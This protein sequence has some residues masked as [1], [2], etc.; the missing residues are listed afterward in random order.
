MFC[1][2]TDYSPL[3]FHKSLQRLISGRGKSIN[4]K[5]SRRICQNPLRP[6]PSRN[7]IHKI[8]KIK[9]KIK[10]Q[11]NWKHPFLLMVSILSDTV[12]LKLL[13]SLG[14][15]GSSSSSGPKKRTGDI[16]SGLSGMESIFQKWRTSIEYFECPFVCD[17]DVM[18]NN[19]FLDFNLPFNAHTPTTPNLYPLSRETFLNN[20]P[21]SNMLLT[22]ALLL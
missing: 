12:P 18:Q 14:L 4:F 20:L 13:N 22:L 17:Y 2:T 8:L 10:I 9:I 15:G 21:L 7:L 3:A 19:Y 11:Q 5:K 6:T 16:G 1:N